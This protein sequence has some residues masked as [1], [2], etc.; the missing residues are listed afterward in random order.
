MVLDT[1]NDPDRP[2]KAR[3]PSSSSRA[4]FPDRYSTPARVRETPAGRPPVSRKL[5][6]PEMSSVLTF[7]DPIPGRVTCGC[8]H[9][10]VA[11]ARAGPQ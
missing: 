5:I 8:A 11:A 10:V 1:V 2:E 3:M 9:P 7:L 6:A 4:R